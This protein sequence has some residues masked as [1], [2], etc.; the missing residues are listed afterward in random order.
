MND[1][2]FLLK[3]RRS[4]DG[5][6]LFLAGSE[7]VAYYGPSPRRCAVYLQCGERLH[8]L[9]EN[10]QNYTNEKWS[11]DGWTV[12]LNGVSR[13]VQEGNSPKWNQTSGKLSSANTE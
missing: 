2:S 6:F 13:R 10:D 8:N 5:L 9:A 12:N 3:C 7:P 11:L 1:V 4:L